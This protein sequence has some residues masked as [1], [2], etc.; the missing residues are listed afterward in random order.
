MPC[1]RLCLHVA[2]VYRRGL[3]T[4]EDRNAKKTLVIKRGSS[5]GNLLKRENIGGVEEGKLA[6]ISNFHTH[7]HKCSSGTHSSS[8]RRS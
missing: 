5:K 1:I 6:R 7:D 3:P 4:R 8:K 2:L